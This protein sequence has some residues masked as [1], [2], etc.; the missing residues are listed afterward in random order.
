MR[1]AICR[2]SDVKRVLDQYSDVGGEHLAISGG[3]PFV[4]KD[5]LEIVEYASSQPL[6][7]TIL[8]N[9]TLITDETAKKLSQYNIKEVQ[10]SLDGAKTETHDALRGMKGA[11]KAGCQRDRGVAARRD[12]RRCRHGRQSS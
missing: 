6:F 9:G 2:S 3:E 11:Q 8:S 7:V 10:I 4:R 12:K 1:G 5:I